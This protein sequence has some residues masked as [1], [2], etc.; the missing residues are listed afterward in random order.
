MGDHSKFT[1]FGIGPGNATTHV[2]RAGGL[3][4]PFEETNEENDLPLGGGGESI[5]LFWWRAGRGG[6]GRAVE[7]NWP[8]E[9]NSVRLDNVAHEGGHGHTSV[10]DFGLA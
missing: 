6:E 3:G 4:I 5:P 7:G 9:M 8:G 2:V 10:L 1:E